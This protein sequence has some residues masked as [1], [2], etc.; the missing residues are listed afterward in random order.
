MKHFER[1]ETTMFR[2]IYWVVE[3]PS[4][5]GDRAV[6]GVYTSIQDLLDSGLNGQRD[7]VRLTLVRLDAENGVLGTWEGPGFGD[8][9]QELEAFIETKEF[10]R[11]CCNDLLSMLQAV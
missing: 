11:D 9:R 1:I 2:R 5:S 4:E 6:T 8:L 7:G 3:R 10:S